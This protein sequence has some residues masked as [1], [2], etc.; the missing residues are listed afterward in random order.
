MAGDRSIDIGNKLS[1]LGHFYQ[2]LKMR[3]Q[4]RRIETF[5]FL[6]GL[7]MAV[8]LAVG[9]H[10][11]TTVKE[12]EHRHVTTQLRTNSKLTEIMSSSSTFVRSSDFP[13]FI[14]HKPTIRWK[15]LKEDGVWGVKFHSFNL[16]YTNGCTTDY[17]YIR[18]LA[19][20]NH[21]VI[22]C[23]KTT[24]EEFISHGSQIEVEFHSDFAK[25]R[26][27]FDFRVE[28]GN[29]EDDVRKQFSKEH[30]EQKPL[31][32][33]VPLQISTEEKAAIISLS[34]ILPIALVIVGLLAIA[35][36][37]HMNGAKKEKGQELPTQCPKSQ[38]YVQSKQSNEDNST[39]VDFFLDNDKMT[40]KPGKVRL[41]EKRMDKTMS[42]YYADMPASLEICTTVASHDVKP[43]PPKFDDKLIGFGSLM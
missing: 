42:N 3:I 33:E 8:S 34:I 10:F 7:L 15:F 20:E 17:M 21:K 37:K 43:P 41:Q 4:N 2:N 11:P 40:V 24:P 5:I 23:G 31:V 9:D 39:V 22:H 18:D 27:Q 6:T 36:A 30:V 25:N 19:R 29:D 16:P 26:P 12:L 38:K 13:A 28:H 1:R 32:I 14:K 35:L